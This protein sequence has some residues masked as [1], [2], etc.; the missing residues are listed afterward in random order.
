[1]YPNSHALDIRFP[2]PSVCSSLK[3][4]DTVDLLEKVF[5]KVKKKIVFCNCRW[6]ETFFMLLIS[7]THT[8]LLENATETVLFLHLWLN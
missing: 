5:V 4:N 7:R 1:M 2:T 6:L 3:I 8:V